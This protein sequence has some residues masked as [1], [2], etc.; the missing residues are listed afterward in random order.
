MSLNAILVALVG[1]W[2]LTRRRVY[3][4]AAAWMMIQYAAGR[5]TIE[6]FRG[7]EIRGVWFGGTLSTSQLLSILLALLGVYLLVKRPGRSVALPAL[8]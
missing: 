5:F 8:A 2:L 7:D 4:V 3:G 1:W 6:F